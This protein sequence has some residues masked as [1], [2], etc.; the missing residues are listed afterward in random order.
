MGEVTVGVVP[1]LPVPGI[2]LVLGNDLA[3]SQVWG[4]PVVVSPPLE[5]PDVPPLV[6]E[7]PEVV[8]QTRKAEAQA[9]QVPPLVEERPG[10]SPSAEEEDLVSLADTV[11]AQAVGCLL[12]VYLL[13]G[14][15]PT[16][17][18]GAWALGGVCAGVGVAAA[19]WGHW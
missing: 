10:V 7:H 12:T 19:H 8:I 16:S 5:V 11:F 9:G 6:P 4:T 14:H 1:T 18:C 17:R 15:V 3:G 13:P 2:S